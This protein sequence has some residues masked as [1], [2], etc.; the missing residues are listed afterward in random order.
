MSWLARLA[1]IEALED[2]PLDASVMAQMEGSQATA[3]GRPIRF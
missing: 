1:A 3:L 2:A